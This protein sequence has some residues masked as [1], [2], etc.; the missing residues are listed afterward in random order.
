MKAV[1]ALHALGVAHGD[2]A[3]RNVGVIPPDDLQC[4]PM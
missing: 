4:G 2:L 3:S 1:E